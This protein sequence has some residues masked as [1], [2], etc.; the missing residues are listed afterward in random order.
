MKY[1]LEMTEGEYLALMRTTE[2][3]VST[4]CGAMANMTGSKQHEVTKVAYARSTRVSDNDEYEKPHAFEAEKPVKEVEHD[5]DW[6]TLD[7]VPSPTWLTPEEPPTGESVGRGPADALSIP[8]E[9]PIPTAPARVAK[10]LPAASGESKHLAKGR[11]VFNGLVALWLDGYE[12]VD[13]PQ[14]DRA[15]AVRGI[16]NGRSAYKVLTYVKSVG[17]LTHAVN[18]AIPASDY[19]GTEQER[20]ALVTSV[21][22]NMTQVTSILFPDLSD[23][24]EY[25][26]IFQSEDNDDE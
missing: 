5:Y 19:A 8:K 16:A 23:L 1:V 9:K 26:N 24:Y 17:G 18:A 21:S 12:V 25:K 11:E 20:Q 3:I 13:A 4:L 15:E 10:P 14:P 7:P 2:N 22:G 6:G